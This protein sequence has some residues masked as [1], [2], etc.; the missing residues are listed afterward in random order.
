M[1]INENTSKEIN[2]AFFELMNKDKYNYKF[3][4]ILEIDKYFADKTINL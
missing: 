3:D 2:E 4:P 1:F